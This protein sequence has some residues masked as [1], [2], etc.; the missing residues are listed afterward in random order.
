MC[1][2]VNRPMS[3]VCL[4]L[5]AGRRSPDRSEDVTSQLLLTCSSTCVS[6]R[7]LS[8]RQRVQHLVEQLQ[9][10]VQVNLQPAGGVLDALSGV[11]APPTFDEAQTHDTQ[12][13]Q[14]VHPQTCRRTHT[15]RERAQVKQL[16]LQPDSS[17]DHILTEPQ[18]TLIT[19]RGAGVYVLI[20]VWGCVSV[21][22]WGG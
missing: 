3:C 10:S 5:S 6:E 20:Q 21:C 1:T 14:V 7:V 22:V 18:V 9:R 16:S 11:V 4:H 12:P 8:R 15:W 13:A 19:T 2:C 17:A